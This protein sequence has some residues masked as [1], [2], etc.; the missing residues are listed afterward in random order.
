MGQLKGITQ[1]WPEQA[2]PP[3]LLA[4]NCLG[5][6]GSAARCLASH[7]SQHLSGESPNGG[8]QRQGNGLKRLKSSPLRADRPPKST[9]L[10]FPMSRLKL[11]CAEGCWN[12]GFPSGVHEKDPRPQSRH[13]GEA[14]D[15][16]SGVHE[17]KRLCKAAKTFVEDSVSALF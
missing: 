9:T 7:F 1:R 17:E 6:A 4:V 10:L 13:G 12:W 2:C 15:G 16:L 5:T 8:D 11:F 3:P 14:P